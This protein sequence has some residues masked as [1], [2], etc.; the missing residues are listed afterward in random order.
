VIKAVA[1]QVAG[2]IEIEAGV[3]EWQRQ[4]ISDGSQRPRL[5]SAYGLRFVEAVLPQPSGEN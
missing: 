2:E 3:L 5:R 4:G 1:E